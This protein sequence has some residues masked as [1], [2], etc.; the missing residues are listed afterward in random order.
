MGRYENNNVVIT[1]GSSGIGLAAAQSLVDEGARVLI[2]GRTQETLDAAAEQLGENAVAVRSDATSLS[3]I[4]A[5]ADR[6]KT[7]FG[8]VDALIGNAGSNN[9]Y[10]PF[11][12]ITEEMFDQNLAVNTKGPYFTIQKLTPLMTEGSGIVLT[13]TIANTLGLPMF[14]TYAAGKAALRSITRSLAR[15]LLPQK[16]RVNAVSPGPIDSGALERVLPPEM[17]EQALAQFIGTTPMQR[18]GTPAEV[19]K[20]MLFLAFDA[21]YTTGAELVV[22]GGTTQ[23]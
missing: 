3:D 9:G 17:V 4:E 21:T 16:I 13:T 22:D 19:V 7:E 8:T 20:A 11:E 18:M 12:T 5:L 10:G 15:E 2:T 1:G 14:S 6:V 23:L